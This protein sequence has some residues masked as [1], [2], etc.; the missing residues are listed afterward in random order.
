MKKITMLFFAA[1]LLLSLSFY[2]AAEETVD[3]QPEV[4]YYGTSMTLSSDLSLNF[5]FLTKNLAGTDYYAVVTKCHEGSCSK[6][7]STKVMPY[8]EWSER[9]GTT[10]IIGIKVRGITAT[11]MICGIKVQ[12][13]KGDPA[14][15]ENG[16]P[17]SV[18]V[19]DSI[20]RCAIVG[21]T[22]GLYSGIE[23]LVVDMLNYGAAA[24]VYFGHNPSHLANIR[25]TDEQKAYASA[26]IGSLSQ[27]GFGYSGLYYGT[28]L[29]LDGTI[30][31]NFYF[32]NVPL[33]AVE[34]LTATVSFTDYLGEYASFTQSVSDMRVTENGEV[35][36]VVVTVKNLT[37]ADFSSLITCKLYSDGSDSPIGTVTDSIELYAKDSLG[38]ATDENIIEL[39]KQIIKYGKS[40]QKAFA[41]SAS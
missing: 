11:E 25:L 10:D 32:E 16:T 31:I 40:A 21:L 6:A 38:N 22:Y 39:Y 14:N 41:V 4:E 29:S 19:T 34:S 8:S 24:Q 20:E 18:A 12:L 3:A 26:D 35:A 9:S 1:L 30:F 15:G 17:V 37:P 33:A 36:T 23:T 27:D 13:Y 5:W 28:S 2:V 7:D